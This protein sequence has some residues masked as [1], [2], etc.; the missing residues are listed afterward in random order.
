MPK[1]CFPILPAQPCLNANHHGCKSEAAEAVTGSQ[2][3]GN[4]AWL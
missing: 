2:V 3:H 4:A 1:A